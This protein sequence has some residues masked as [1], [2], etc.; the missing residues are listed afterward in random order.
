MKP[1]SE[2]FSADDPQRILLDSN[3]WVADK[4]QDSRRQIGYAMM[5]IINE[6]GLIEIKGVDGEIPSTRIDE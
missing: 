1:G 5:E 6:T 3:I 4:T 2:S